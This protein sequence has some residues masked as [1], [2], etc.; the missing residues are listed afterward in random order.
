MIQ[1]LRWNIQNG[2]GVDGAI[3]LERIAATIFNMS[4]PDVICL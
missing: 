1:I 3:S 2:E 4:A